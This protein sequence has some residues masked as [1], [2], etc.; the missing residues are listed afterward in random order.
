MKETLRLFK[1]YLGERTNGVNQD[2]L[3]YGLLIPASASNEVVKEAI[4]QYGKDGLKWNQTFHKDLEI[5]KNAPI[6][7]LVIQQLIHYITTYG[8]E[9][10]GCYNS[11]LVY[12]PKEKLEV[13]ELDI[14]NIELINI[15]PI[16]ADELTTK[17]MVLLTSGIA[18]SKQTIQDIMVLS[19]YI[20][21]DRF[22]EI[23]NREIRI[24]LYDK[25]RIMPKNPENFLR[26]LIFKTTG[27]T[28][29]IQSVELINKIKNKLKTCVVVLV[30]KN[31][32]KINLIF[33][34]TDDLDLNANEIIKNFL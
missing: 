15:M 19:D 5:V 10:L 9:A 26:F 32:N 33:S 29:K 28:L 8:F 1:S 31:E 12:I 3:K 23:A 34:R 14:D 2:A 22:D 16:T 13:P 25:Y 24:A 7:D 30:N 20:D 27:D 4:S 18:L 17:L 6:E 21:K 11:D